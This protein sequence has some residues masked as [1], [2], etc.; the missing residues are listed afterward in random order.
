MIEWHAC[1]KPC[2]DEPHKRF[3]VD[4]ATVKGSPASMDIVRATLPPSSARCWVTPTTTSSIHSGT[5]RPL[6]TASATTKAANS[7]PRTFRKTPLF[8][9]DR[10]IAVRQ[11]DTTTGVVSGERDNRVISTLKYPSLYGFHFLSTT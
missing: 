8:T 6:A 11:Q 7:S 1:D 3:V 10:P 4:A 5:T 9:S 2:N